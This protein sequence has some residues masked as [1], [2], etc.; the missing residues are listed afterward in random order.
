MSEVTTL[1]E[2]ILSGFESGLST[3]LDQW[4][5]SIVSVASSKGI[6][7]DGPKVKS[8]IS[9]RAE[10]KR[11]LSLLGYDRLL[12]DLMASYDDVYKE[13]ANEVT[14]EVGESI[15][16]LNTNLIRSLREMDYTFLSELGNASVRAVSD[17]V[18]RNAIAGTPRSQLVIKVARE[19]ELFKQHAMTYIDTALV[20]YDRT[21]KVELLQKAGVTKFRYSGPKDVKSRAFCLSHVGNVYTKAQI[22]RMHNGTKLMPVLIYGGGW[23]CRHTW[24][25]A[26]L[27]KRVA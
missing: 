24:T 22:L 1:I 10:I 18:T 7:S 6:L 13:V 11:Q 20:T 9:A 16:R 4:N 3:V 15:G 21:V 5:H 17:A 27:P 23:N 14:S 12:N 26:A 25:A 19:L 8:T 2:A